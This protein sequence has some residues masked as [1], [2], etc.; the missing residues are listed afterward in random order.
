MAARGSSLR[1]WALAKG[2]QPGTVTAAVK[3]WAYR[4]DQTPH[5]G[6][7]RQIMADL[8][9]DLPAKTLR[10]LSTRSLSRAVASTIDQREVA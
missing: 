4:M 2:Y 6:I 7:N 9:A 10:S 1:A 3:R 8:K 5:G